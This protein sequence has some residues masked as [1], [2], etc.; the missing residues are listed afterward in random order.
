M[1]QVF[2]FGDAMARAGRRVADEQHAVERAQGS[3]SKRS[4]E[5]LGLVNADWWVRADDYE[6]LAI[7]AS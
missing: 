7:G 2:E 6:F 1:P 4:H 5:W 3:G